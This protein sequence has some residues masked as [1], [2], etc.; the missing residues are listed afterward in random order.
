VL[1]AIGGKYVL[2]L[3][4]P[5]TGAARHVFNPSMFGVSVSLLVGRELITASPAY[6]WAGSSLTVTFFL[7]TAAVLLFVTRI[8][9]GW[10]VVS[11]LVFYAVNTAIRC[12]VMRHHLPPEMLFLGTMTT[13]PFYLFTLYMITD[14]QT[15]PK[16]P[17]QQVLVAFSIA[18]VDLVL[19]TKESVYTF[20]Y[21]ALIVA[22]ARFFFAHAKALWRDGPAIVFAREFDRRRGRAVLA[23]GAIGGVYAGVL[24]ASAPHL[25]PVHPGFAFHRASAEDAGLG[26]EMSTLLEEVD[27]RLRHV[28]KWILSVGDAVAAADVDNDG[29]VDVFLTNPLKR[30]SDRAALYLN[31]STADDLRFERASPPVLAALD[32]LVADP[33]GQGIASGATFVDLDG[34]GDQDLVVA[35]SFGKSR[36]LLNRLIEDGIEKSAA[37]GVEDRAPRFED[38]SAQSGVDAHTISLQAAA[39]DVENDGD[40]DLLFLNAAAP[41]L[42][43][44]DPPR[45]LNAFELPAPEYDGDR[46]MLRFMHDGWH[47]ADN[48]GGQVLYENRGDGTFTRVDPAISGLDGHR[49]SLAVSAV[50]FNHDGFVDL[51]VANDFGPDELFLNTGIDT[52]RAA[53]VARQIG[54][55][56]GAPRFRRVTGTMFNDV[57]NDTYK[58]MNAS[59]ADFD[60]NGYLDVAVSNVHHALQAEGS[61]L[62]M[63]R[64]GGG[65]SGDDPFVPSFS[66]EATR[67]GALNERRFGWGACA[68][69]LD[70]DGWTDLVQANGMV[71]D[72]LDRLLPDGA[73]KDYW[74]V[75]HK[76]MQSGPDVHTYADMWGD[77]RGRTIYPNEKRRAYLNL[78]AAA[79]G[80]MPA[81]FVDVADQVGLADPDNSRG[82]LLSDLDA[83]GDLDALVTNQHGPVSLYASDLRAR[84]PD[85]SHFVSLLLR[86]SGKNRDA[87]GAVVTVAPAGR[88]RSSTAVAGE[89]QTQQ[90]QLTCGFSAQCDPRLH[91]GLGARS[92]PIDVTVRWPSGGTTR[93]TLDADRMHV[94]EEPR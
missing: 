40:L 56:V 64:P 67:R 9:R 69:D 28:A 78:G 12:V 72:R 46:R 35:V 45:P 4:D 89:L 26:T 94:I 43:T 81:Y 77:I 54:G 22:T 51:Y 13:P 42:N 44:Y 32:D 11:F 2:T 80:G 10:L 62:W 14:P 58:G 61:M 1:L 21:A 16:T 50:D 73:R 36:V 18:A 90:R 57:G 20:F 60:R 65:D 23:A 68:G 52:G 15:S 17:G 55:G 3:R 86:G 34:D 47:D 29:D 19:H 38:V 25:A 7:I 79:R 24:W 6:Q 93:A 27:P 41:L 39:F 8:G 76:L 49:W 48:G 30:P 88:E 75:N 92:G 87:I 82:V 74:Y 83:D 53:G 63:V 66:D 91:F 59:A 37:K 85:D 33:K 70:N 31:A 84:R 5:N 71:D